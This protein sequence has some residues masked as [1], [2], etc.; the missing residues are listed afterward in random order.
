ME[1]I[2]LSD[3]LGNQEMGADRLGR[4]VNGS[5]WIGEDRIGL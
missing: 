4:E 5:E 3:W 2:G 1:R